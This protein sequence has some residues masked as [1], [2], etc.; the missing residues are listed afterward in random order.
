MELKY[1]SWDDITLAIYERLN[2][3]TE[4]KDDIDAINVNMGLL[5][6]LCD[7]DI[8]QIENLE[9][10]KFNRLVSELNYLGKPYYNSVNT[11]YVLN[12]RK[13]ILQ[14]NVN[15]MTTAQYIDFQTYYKLGADKRRAEILSCILI[16]DGYKYNDGYDIAEIIELIKN[17]MPIPDVLGLCDFF[18]QSLRALTIATLKSSIRE[19]RKEM[20]MITDLNKRNEI[21]IKIKELKQRIKDL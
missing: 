4:V 18:L 19:M 8:E 2:I 3:D 12:G 11:E 20:K 21:E 15:T 1:K 7:C 10:S 9:I 13:L 5:S 17:Y 14:C 6:V 16:P